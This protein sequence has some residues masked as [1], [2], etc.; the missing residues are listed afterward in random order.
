MVAQ[1]EYEIDSNDD[2][3]D[4]DEGVFLPCF[5][6]SMDNMTWQRGLQSLSFDC[7]HLDFFGRGTHII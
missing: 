6:Q 2:D 4:D 1:R 7:I 3:D 5:N